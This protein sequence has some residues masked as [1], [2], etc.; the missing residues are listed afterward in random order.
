MRVFIKLQVN[1]SRFYSRDSIL[2]F[3]FNCN[4]LQCLWIDIQSCC[5]II[6]AFH[7]AIGKFTAGRKK[8]SKFQQISLFV[9]ENVIDFLL[10][11]L[12]ASVMKFTTL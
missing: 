8:T 4:A 10:P 6:N 3:I 12:F 5:T 9:Q 7:Y 2:L 11:V 1:N